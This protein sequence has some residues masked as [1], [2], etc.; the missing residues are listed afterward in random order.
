[1]AQ[2]SLGANGDY[3]EILAVGTPHPVLSDPAAAGGIIRY[4]PA[5]PH[6]GAVGAP[7]NDPTARVIATGR[8][9]VSGVTFNIADC[10][11]DFPSLRRP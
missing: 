6:E 5:H 10:R 9:R 1:M 2:L 8:S 11:I 7:K 3:Q 4:L